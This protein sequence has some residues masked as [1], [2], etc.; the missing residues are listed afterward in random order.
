MKVKKFDLFSGGDL[1]DVYKTHT[2]N[3][4]FLR[5]MPDKINKTDYGIVSLVTFHSYEL[6]I[7][8]ITLIL[9]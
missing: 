9:F 7:K 8:Y 1:D 4:L 5:D 3:R 6:I 2:F